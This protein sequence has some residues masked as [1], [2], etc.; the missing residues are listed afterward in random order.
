MIADRWAGLAVHQRIV[1]EVQANGDGGVASA[2]A[3]RAEWI[4]IA[5]TV[6]RVLTVNQPIDKALPER[7]D[8][9]GI[10]DRYRRGAVV[11]NRGAVAG[12]DQVNHEPVGV[13]HR[14]HVEFHFHGSRGTE[15]VRHLRVVSAVD[16]RVDLR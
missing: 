4:E 3:G 11:W 6:E 10:E 5:L 13:L 12:V 16:D 1:D 14:R 15:V 8:L 2:G 9:T 7:G